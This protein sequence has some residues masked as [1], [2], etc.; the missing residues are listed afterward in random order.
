MVGTSEINVEV[1]N[2]DFEYSA[3]RNPMTVL[4][5]GKMRK[6]WQVA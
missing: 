3:I 1:I 6:N 5:D 2:S 4:L